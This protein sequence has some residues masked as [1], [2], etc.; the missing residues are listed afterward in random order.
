MRRKTPAKQIRAAPETSGPCP[1]VCEARCCRYITTILPPPKRK[2]EFDELSWFL[3]HEGVS[4]YV[5]GRRWHLEV[6][7][8][9]RYLRPDNL[10]AI[11]ENRPS[12]CRDHEPE[13]CEHSAAIE[14][15]LHFKTREE[16]D[17]WCAERRER[18]KRRR[19]SSHRR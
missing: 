16:F 5:Q 10:C 7:V 18:E 11:Y 15:A 9:C 13:A 2:V 1:L 4:I 14:Y 6:A 12:V 17:R 8:T 19:S 3:A